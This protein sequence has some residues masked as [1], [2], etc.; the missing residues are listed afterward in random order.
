MAF[1]RQTENFLKYFALMTYQK[2][3]GIWD[4]THPAD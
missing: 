2:R 3:L 1:K 4:R